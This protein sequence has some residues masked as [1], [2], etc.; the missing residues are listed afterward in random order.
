MQKRILIMILTMCVTLM[1]YAQKGLYTEIGFGIGS[2]LLDYS[3]LN[4][5]FKS[6]SSPGHTN[7]GGIGFTYQFS[8]R[9]GLGVGL[10]YAHY[11]SN[12]KINGTQIWKDVV[13]TDTEIY[14]HHLQVD[15]W[16]EKTMWTYLDCPIWLQYTYPVIKRLKIQARVGIKYG[17]IQSSRFQANGKLVHTGYYPKWHLTIHDIPAEG[18]YTQSSFEPQGSIESKNNISTFGE[19]GILYSISKQVDIMVS[20]Y[21]NYGLTQGLLP[22]GENQI[23][24]QNDKVNMEKAHYFMTSYV[25]LSSV[26]YSDVASSRLNSQGIRVRLMVQLIDFKRRKKCHCIQT[27]RG[28]YRRRR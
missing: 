3:L 2:S 12:L 14:D 28:H 11:A 21:Y 9:W 25:P 22:K 24:F 23:G 5:S 8:K 1:S 20:A 4:S 13:D 6:S 10:D 16:N 26:K 18:F 15:D 19:L 7:V 17:F 27:R